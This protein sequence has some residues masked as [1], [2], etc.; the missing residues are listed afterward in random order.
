MKNLNLLEK[1]LKNMEVIFFILTQINIMK[2]N[3]ICY[4]CKNLVKTGIEKSQVKLRLDGEEG[5]VI[6]DYK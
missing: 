2:I 6:D 3:K 1:I 5:I 4:K